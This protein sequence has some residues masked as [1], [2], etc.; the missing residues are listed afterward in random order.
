MHCNHWSVNKYVSLKG[1]FRWFHLKYALS[2]CK[3][4]VN[5]LLYETRFGKKEPLNL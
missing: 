3:M 5:T 4:Y 1:K 2:A